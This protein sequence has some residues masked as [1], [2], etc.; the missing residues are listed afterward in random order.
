MQRGLILVSYYGRTIDE[1]L[2]LINAFDAD[3]NQHH[4]PVLIVDNAGTLKSGSVPGKR[5]IEVVHGSNT[6]WEFSGWLEGL[7]Q[8]SKWNNVATITLLND[9][10]QRNWT[11][12]SASRYLVRSMY[13]AADQGL[14]AG[15]LDNFSWF[16]R[17]RFSRRPNSRLVVLAWKERSHISTSL[18]AAINRCRSIVKR[19][20]ELF[21]PDDA[22]RLQDWI[23][24]QSGRWPP[25]TLPARLQRIY[26]EHHLFDSVLARQLALFPKSYVTAMLYAVTRRWFRESR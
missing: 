23:A 5:I 16:R 10:Y 25:E 11:V 22:A 2:R 18:Q 17:P 12:T 1:T 4:N 6:A 24:S 19:G 3:T 21:D 14:I 7:N 15:W 13:E 26:L 9:S 20:D 8:I